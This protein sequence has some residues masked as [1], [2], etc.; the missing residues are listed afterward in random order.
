MAYR[1]NPGNAVL[2][3]YTRLELLDRAHVRQTPAPVPFAERSP[4]ERRGTIA[5]VTSYLVFEA[6]KSRE[7]ALSYRD[8][9]VGAAALVLYWREGV[10]F[11]TYIHGANMK[12]TST[13]EINVHAEHVLLRSIEKYMRPD[14]HVSVP[15][16]SV[17]GDYQADQQS[18]KHT[19]TLHPC[20]VCRGDFQTFE[21]PSFE[22]TLFVTAKPDLQVFEWFSLPE[23]TAHHE[24]ADQELAFAEFDHPLD[25]FSLPEAELAEHQDDISV[26]ERL[27]DAR[28]RIPILVSDTIS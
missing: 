7:F 17:I 19:R 4:L 28:V 5:N 20:G 16:V 15:I 10:E 3:S 6:Q 13:D 22:T 24:G 9:R 23:L 12:P 14:D 21:R 2:E 8:F 26:D 18:G 1:D 11:Q 25:I 27:F